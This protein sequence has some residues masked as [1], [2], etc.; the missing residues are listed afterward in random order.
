MFTLWHGPQGNHTLDEKDV[1]RSHQALA[2]DNL[3]RVL[4]KCTRPLQVTYLSPFLGDHISALES[5]YPMTCG[6]VQCQATIWE[7]ESMAFIVKPIFLPCYT[8]L[9]N[10]LTTGM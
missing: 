5:G 10:L 1:V 6:Y 3:V 4:Q 7:A 2:I 9:R 8:I